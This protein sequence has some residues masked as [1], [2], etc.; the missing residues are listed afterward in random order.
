MTQVGWTRANQLAKGEAISI[1]TIKRIAAFARHE[2]NSKIDVIIGGPPCQ[3]FSSIRPFRSIN[4]KDSRNNLYEEFGRFLW[5]LKPEIF[6]LENVVSLLT[7][8]QGKSVQEIIN[9]FKRLTTT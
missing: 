3:G 2:K 6:V 4:E 1:E 8:R 9:E 5:L 7:Y